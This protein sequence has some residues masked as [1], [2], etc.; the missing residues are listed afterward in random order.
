MAGALHGSGEPEVSINVGISGP[1]VVRN[2]VAR[3]PDL[4]FTD[5]ADLIKRTTFK[6]TRVGELVA[7]EAAEM[8]DAQMGIIT[9]VAP[10]PAVGDSIAEILEAWAWRARGAGHHHGAGNAERRRQKGGTMATSSTGGLSAPSSRRARTPAWR[11][12]R[13]RACSRSRSSRR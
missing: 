11:A 12:P 1:G 10:S 5:L 3:H 6:I 2:V 8:L 7:R 9:L 13:Q 4:S